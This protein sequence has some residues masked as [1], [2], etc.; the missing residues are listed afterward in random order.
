MMILLTFLHLEMCLVL[1]EKK[2]LLKFN[3]LFSQLEWQ[4]MLGD[5]CRVT[6]YL[7]ENFLHPKLKKYLLS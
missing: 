7:C 1:F 4:K 3:L 2:A 5:L 6:Y